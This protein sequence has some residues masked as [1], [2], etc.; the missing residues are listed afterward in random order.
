MI[1]LLVTWIL[2]K[3][4]VRGNSTTL[5]IPPN[6]LIFLPW[7]RLQ[8]YPPEVGGGTVHSVTRLALSTLM[9]IISALSGRRLRSE[10]ARVRHLPRRIKRTNLFYAELAVLK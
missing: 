8:V 10:W 9:A 2:L 5:V 3:V 4:G 6:L 1:Y 7:P